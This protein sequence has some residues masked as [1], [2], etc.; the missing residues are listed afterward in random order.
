MKY[1]FQVRP[2]TPG[3]FQVY[4]AAEP[5]NYA[6]QAWSFTDENKARQFGWIWG[7]YWTFRELIPS[8]LD[9]QQYESLC[10]Q[11]GMKASSDKDIFGSYGV[12]Y[13]EF[14]PE[15]HD[16]EQYPT[17]LAWGKQHMIDSARLSGIRVERAAN[18]PAPKK[19][20]P[21]EMVEADC[22]HIIPRR[23]LM[24]A[25]MGSS[26]PDCYDRMSN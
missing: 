20:Q 15:H 25:S 11:H 5:N 9:R 19:L 7:E 22:G 26:C 18:P 3:R 13:G 10:A 4:N 1:D 21:V 6:L 23:Q 2:T 24:S 17:L 12:M 8:P 16:V 14:A